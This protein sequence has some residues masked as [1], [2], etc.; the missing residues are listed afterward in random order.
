MSS[1]I[2]LEYALSPG[3]NTTDFTVIEGLVPFEGA[4]PFQAFR[5]WATYDPGTFVIR[6]DGTL[7]IEGYPTAQ[8]VFNMMTKYQLKH[9]MDAYCGGSY[10]G[11]VTVKT[12]TDVP[13]TLITCNAVM[14]IDKL[15]LQNPY[16]GN[17][18]PA[19]IRFTRIVPIVTPLTLVESGIGLQ[20]VSGEQWNL[21]NT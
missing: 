2:E 9:L 8:W 19:T 15:P 10:S 11:L 14:T 20:F 7:L 1:C 13:D 3:Y 21:V 6:G 5:G 18:L 4:L 16:F 17:Y 12:T